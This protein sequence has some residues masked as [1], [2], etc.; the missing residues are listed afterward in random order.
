MPIYKGQ[1]PITTLKHGDSTISNVYHGTVP[2]F[3]AVQLPYRV[4]ITGASPINTYATAIDNW[5]QG[6]FGPAIPLYFSVDNT[7]NNG[8]IW[9]GIVLNSTAF[10]LMHN[11]NKGNDS[12]SMTIDGWHNFLSFYLGSDATDTDFS[13]FTINDPFY[14]LDLGEWNTSTQQ[15]TDPT[16]TH[17]WVFTKNNGYYSVEYRLLN[18]S[19]FNYIGFLVQSGVEVVD[20]KLAPLGMDFSGAFDIDIAALIVSQQINFEYVY[21]MPMALEWLINNGTKVA[22]NIIQSN[23]N[24]FNFDI[25]SKMTPLWPELQQL[26][27]DPVTGLKILQI[28]NYT[29]PSYN[30]PGTLELDLISL[31]DEGENE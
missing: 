22:S 28:V 21:N 30:V 6:F 18:N 2:V 29:P 11:V 25:Y 14:A 27:W 24:N 26:G 31:E 12:F 10:N 5:E 1:T 13:H 20:L 19:D 15:P 8:S 9:Y 3:N 16:N 7:S 23:T 17:A 4:N